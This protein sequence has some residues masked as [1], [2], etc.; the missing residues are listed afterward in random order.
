MERQR[1]YIGARYVPRFLGTYDV[2]Q[3][4]DALDVVDNG[5]GTSYIAR[6]P[7]PAGTPLTNTE[8][9]F[10]YGASTGAILQLQNEMIQA[11]N[12]ILTNAN[13]IDMI[14]NR[15]YLIFGD[16]YDVVSSVGASWSNIVINRLGL[17]AKVLSK[18]YAGFIGDGSH[19]T[20]LDIFND[21]T[22]TAPEKVTDV[23]ILGGTNDH[24]E[25]ASSLLGPMTALKN[26]ILTRCPNVERFHIGFDGYCI[27]YNNTYTE[28]FI[29]ARKA[30]YTNANKLGWHI[31]PNICYALYN[32]SLFRETT[33]SNHPSEEGVGKIADCL[34]QYLLTGYCDVEYT[35]GAT[36]N[37]DTDNVDA[38]GGVQTV[39]CVGYF[40]NG[41]LHFRMNNKAFR[42]VAAWDRLNTG[43]LRLGTIDAN[44]NFLPAHARRSSCP[45]RY[46]DGTA[47]I[48]N[49]WI[50][51]GWND[52]KELI[53]RPNTVPISYNIP[54]NTTITIIASALDWYYSFD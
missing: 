38:V 36:I 10:V 1:Q 53:I 43:E 39:L 14:K 34:T 6:K 50:A 3:I 2:T 19:D 51:F 20:W 47:G 13:D 26:A 21:A 30:Y 4:Y 44:A 33:Q 29:T 5:S 40:K 15:R 8:Y 32:P 45:I 46:T 52:D 49:D 11:Q 48:V 16:S 17:N 28:S 31:I 23:I 27:G 37:L 18:G 9:W 41:N 35:M 22:L 12:D 25:S 54:A 7:V 24:T 42:N